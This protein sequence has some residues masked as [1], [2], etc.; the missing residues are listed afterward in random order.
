MGANPMNQT[1]RRPLL[2]VEHLSVTYGGLR[3]VD[4][5]GFTMVEPSVIGLIGP[6]GAGKTTTIDAL[7]GFV[8]NAQGSV[9]LR[10]ERIDTYGAHDRARAGLVRTFQSVELFDDLSVR[11]NLVVASARPRWWSMASDAVTPRR[12]LRRHN[13]DDIITMVGLEPIADDHPPQLSHGQRRIVGVARALAGAPKVLLLDEPAAGLDPTETE[14]LGALIRSLPSR[15][16][17]VLL[18]D[19]DMTL[20]LDVCDELFVLDFGRL[21]AS[22]TPGVIRNDPAVIAAYLGGTV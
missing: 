2:I 1:G 12:N 22:G 6:N 9:S 7:T 18:V 4:D 21:I 14:A 5:V 11:E 8:P 19:H 3:A 17:G 16:I 15:G 10:G 13:V 20:V